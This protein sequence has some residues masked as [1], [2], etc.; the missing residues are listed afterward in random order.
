MESKATALSQLF[1]RVAVGASFLSAVADRFGIWGAPGTPGVAWGSWE[2]FMAY[3]S[4][5]NSFASPALSLFLGVV[6]TSLEVILALLLLAG[7]KTRFAALASGFLLAAFGLGM[8][9]SFGIKP[10]L[11]YSVWSAAAGSFLLGAFATFPYSV[12]KMISKNK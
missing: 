7:F 9:F 5:L 3:S 1:L 10:A 12:D 2:N 11:D 6:A 4:S 8:T